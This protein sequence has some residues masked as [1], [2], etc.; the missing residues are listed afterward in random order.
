MQGI[1]SAEDYSYLMEKRAKFIPLQELEKLRYEGVITESDYEIM[2]SSLVGLEDEY[3]FFLSVLN[4]IN[5]VTR[6]DGAELVYKT[7]IYKLFDTENHRSYQETMVLVIVTITCFISH[8]SRESEMLSLVK[9]TLRG[10][11]D[12]ALCKLGVSTILS[13]MIASASFFPTIYYLN[14]V[15]GLNNLSSPACSLP[16]FSGIPKNMSINVLIVAL[17]FSRMAVCVVVSIVTVVISI[18]TRKATTAFMISSIVF[19][20]PLVLGK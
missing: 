11:K 12:T 15:Y 10:R 19:I 2:H 20:L 3:E 16:F 17:F 6:Q 14:K 5:Y 18:K 9:S 4:D 13:T 8:G 1:Y 7:G